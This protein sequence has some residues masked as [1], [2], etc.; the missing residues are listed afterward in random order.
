MAGD[1]FRFMQTFLPPGPQAPRGA[2]WQPPADVYRT[3]YGWLIKF[4][5]AGVRP[6]DVEVSVSGS[7]LTVRGVRRDLSLEEGCQ[8]YQMEIAYS[9]FERSLTLPINLQDARIE[10]EHRYGLLL[11]YVRPEANRR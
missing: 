11:V 9:R 4:D 2:A 8:Y 1:L 6:E 5:L 7:R 3:R 10:A